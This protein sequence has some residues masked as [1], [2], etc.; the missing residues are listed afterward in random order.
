MNLP[1]RKVI[2]EVSSCLLIIDLDRVR[3]KEEEEEEPR[4]IGFLEGTDILGAMMKRLNEKDKKKN[5]N[6]TEKIRCRKEG[7]RMCNA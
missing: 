1:V 4:R 5:R 7:I 6:T 3:R 2:R